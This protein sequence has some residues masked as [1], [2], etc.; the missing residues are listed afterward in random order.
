[1][2]FKDIFVV[3]TS[4]AG[5]AHVIDFAGQ[6]AQQQGG[7]I[8]TWVVGWQPGLPLASEVWVADPS[9]GNSLTEAR[10][11]LDAEAAAVRARFD[12]LVGPVPTNAVLLEYGAA[13]PVIGMRARL[14]DVTV[15]SR[16]PANSPDTDQTI[17]EAV[18]FHSGRP[19]IIVPPGWVRA[20]IGQSVLVCWKPTRESA[21]ALGD[22]AP[23][24]ASAT[25]VSVVTVDARPSGDG[26][27]PQPGADISAHLARRGCQ[28]ELINVDSMGRTEA[29]AIQDQARAVAAD[30][31]VMGGFGHSRLSEM[32]FG[33]VT[34][35][36]LQTSTVPVLMSH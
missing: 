9:W 36:F 34:R 35:E 7:K 19:V 31:I 33:G 4:A 8:S 21:R 27:G 30:L 11:E 3:A 2:S 20:P 26:D 1:M 28:A 32:V 16:P 13:A 23:L 25:K 29:A 22:A 24:L 18:L 17:L 5:S 10:K 6:L 15:V 12:H 14:S